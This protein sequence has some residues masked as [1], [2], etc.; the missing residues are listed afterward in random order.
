MT[1][2]FILTYQ[3]NLRIHTRQGKLYYI[4]PLGPTGSNRSWCL[5][6]APQ[7]E[8]DPLAP[9]GAGVCTPPPSPELVSPPL[10]LLTPPAPSE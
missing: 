3:T 10:P 9:A 8:L 2:K 5:H 7:P 4:T 6:T 1:H